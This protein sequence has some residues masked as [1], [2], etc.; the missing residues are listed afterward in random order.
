MRRRLGKWHDTAAMTELEESPAKLMGAGASTVY[1]RSI[2]PERWEG[3]H[4][5]WPIHGELV[6]GGTAVG[7]AQPLALIVQT[8]AGASY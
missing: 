8:G 3:E 4:P 5:G 7:A 1:G 2:S 6:G